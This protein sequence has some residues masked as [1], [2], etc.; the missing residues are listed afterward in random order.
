MKA[1]RGIER[2]DA[3]DA[4]ADALAALAAGEASGDQVLALRAHLRHC[5]GCRAAFRELHLGRRRLALALP[6]PALAQWLARLAAPD[7]VAGV[8]VAGTAGAARVPAA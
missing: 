8:Q 1:Y 3:C 5:G 4:H 7:L 2:G 6:L